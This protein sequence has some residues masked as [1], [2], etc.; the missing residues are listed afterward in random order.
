MEKDYLYTEV[1]VDNYKNFRM[2]RLKKQ[3][4]V[5]NKQVTRPVN[6]VSINCSRSISGQ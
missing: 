5:T 3:R 1:V 4:R 2:R 6:E